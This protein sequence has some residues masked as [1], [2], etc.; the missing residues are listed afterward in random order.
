MPRSLILFLL[1]LIG[2]LAGF[3][4]LRWLIILASPPPENLGVRD[5]RLAACPNNRNCVST[6]ETGEQWAI[7]PISYSGDTAVARQRILTILADA[8]HVTILKADANYIHAE[9]RTFL[10]G[11]V[12]DVEFQFDEAA[13][14]IHFR[15][16][17]RL[18]YGDIGANRARMEAIRAAWNG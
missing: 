7:D 2:G 12:D 6:S 11:F 5:G 16:A 1:I 14:L 9:F 18:G 4:L 13:G 3:G 15:S 17:G 10:W 8:P